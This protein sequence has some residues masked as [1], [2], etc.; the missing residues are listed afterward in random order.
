SILDAICFALYGTAPRYDGAQARLRS[1]HAAVG[2]PTRVELVF[3]VRGERWRV[4]RSPEYERPKQRGTGTTREAQA[5]TLERWEQAV[6]ARLAALRS[7]TER[8]AALA[9][10]DPP[11]DGEPD[12]AAGV[13]DR[14]TAT[15]TGAEQEADDARAAFSAADA[16]AAAAVTTADLQRRRVA[17]R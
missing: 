3:T 7:D 4:T 12:W 5:A 14:L 2:V 11:E 10:V 13:L 16:L 9:D 8:L 17:A 15:A 1:D 6:G